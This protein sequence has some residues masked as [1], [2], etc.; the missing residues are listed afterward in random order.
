MLSVLSIAMRASKVSRSRLR[1]F[2]EVVYE[3]AK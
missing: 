1:V 2:I 3:P